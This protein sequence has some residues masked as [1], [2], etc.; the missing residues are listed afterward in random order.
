MRW[1]IICYLTPEKA[2]PRWSWQAGGHLSG[3]WDK[4]VIW[5]WSHCVIVIFMLQNSR[6]RASFLSCV[7][8]L[9]EPICL[10]MANTNIF[11]G[12][13]YFLSTLQLS[14][15]Q[16][17]QFKQPTQVTTHTHTHTHTHN[18]TCID[19]HTQTLVHTH[20]GHGSWGTS[21]STEHTLL[22]LTL[23]KAN[24]NLQFPVIC[25]QQGPTLWQKGKEKRREEKRRGEERRGEEHRKQK[26][27]WKWSWKGKSH[28]S[29]TDASPHQLYEVRPIIRTSHSL[30]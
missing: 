12:R 7:C 16:A 20:V 17:D 28:T 2:E 15:L 26:R 24:I 1:K 29:H 18:N 6:D 25:L 22:N 8:V 27:R 4:R 13:L 23:N 10:C 9:R 3:K 14:T 5:I 21:I 11:P 19:T 30:V